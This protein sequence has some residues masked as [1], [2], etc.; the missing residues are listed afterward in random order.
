MLGC[1]VRSRPPVG[2]P[3]VARSSRPPRP[4]PAPSGPGATGMLNESKRRRQIGWEKGIPDFA[5]TSRISFPCFLSLRDPPAPPSP[6]REGFGAR[7]RSRQELGLASW[8]RQ[9]PVAGL[10]QGAQDPSGRRRRPTDPR[11]R[12]APRPP[13]RAVPRRPAV[14][15]A[16]EGPPPPTPAPDR[17]SLF[18]RRCRASGRGVRTAAQPQPRP[19]PGAPRRARPQGR[20]SNRG[21][22][23]GERR[24]APV[25]PVGVPSET[26]VCADGRRWGTVCC[27]PPAACLLLPSLTPFRGLKNVSVGAREPPARR[28]T[29]A[30]RQAP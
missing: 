29:G 1:S 5:R 26:P 7:R 12:G 18:H 22:L 11:V 21:L 30:R 14:S 16:P 3:P 25:A 19:R 27:Y 15:P 24:G 6:Y 20:F 8:G 4:F 23:W 2:P 17:W 13:P 28:T 9:G 10:A